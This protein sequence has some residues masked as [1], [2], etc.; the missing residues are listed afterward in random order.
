MSP[1]SWNPMEFLG[2]VL[3]G[4]PVAVLGGSILFAI[5]YLV[6]AFILYVPWWVTTIALLT[7]S[8]FIGLIILG[9]I[10]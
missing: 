7:L 5:S 10:D 9:R 4:V 2:W 6:I 3:L 8:A 1:K